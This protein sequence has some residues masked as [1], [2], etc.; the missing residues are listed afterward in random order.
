M[1]NKMKL[2]ICNQGMHRSKTCAK[3]FNS[4]FAGIYS[5]KNPLTKELLEKATIIY[6]FEQHQRRFIAE[7]FP[8]EYM[9]KKII[10]LDILDIY[11]YMDEEL[12]KKI[13][14]KKF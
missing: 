6:V 14:E 1:N 9:A 4:K 8:K 3:L 12:I 11:S 7:N 13:K 5:Q 10:C 2:F